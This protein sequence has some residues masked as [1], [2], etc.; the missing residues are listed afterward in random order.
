MQ[1]M[2]FHRS[3]FVFASVLTSGIISCNSNSVEKHAKVSDIGSL[4]KN[5]GIKLDIENFIDTSGKSIKIDF[6]KS[7][8]TIV[9]FWINECP[10]CNAEMSQFADLIKGKDKQISII[11]ISVSGF[12]FWKQLFIDKGPRY[13][14]LKTSV[15]N[16]QHVNLKSEND[17]AFKNL[18]STDRL[19]EITEKWNVTF[20]PSYFVVNKKGKILARPISAVEYIKTQL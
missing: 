6:T 4:T 17:P 13:F 1:H 9:D 19:T 12:Q 18:I 14:F 5:V 16:W 10:P 7:D 11:S 20:F 15:S 3:I 8:I 2:K